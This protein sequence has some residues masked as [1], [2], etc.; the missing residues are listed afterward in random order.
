M[1]CVRP[2]RCP[3]ARLLWA[4]G[5][6]EGEGTRRPSVCGEQA[7]LVCCLP[8]PASTASTARHAK[9]SVQS[10]DA[11]DAPQDVGNDLRDNAPS[12]DFPP[13]LPRRQHAVSLRLGPRPPPPARAGGAEQAK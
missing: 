6:E 1:S 7:E 8:P 9:R 4:G 2:E 5:G 11:A 10:E 12:E 13:G 3:E